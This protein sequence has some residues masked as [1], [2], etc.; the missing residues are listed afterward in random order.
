VDGLAHWS[1]TVQGAI[2]CIAN[3]AKAT[4]RIRGR[5]A[6]HSGRDGFLVRSASSQCEGRPAGRGEDGEK[7]SRGL[8]VPRRGGLLAPGCQVV[9][10][11][12][13]L[14]S[15]PASRLRA[16]PAARGII[17]SPGGYESFGMPMHTSSIRPAGLGCGRYSG[18]AVNYCQ[19]IIR[20][21]ELGWRLTKAVEGRRRRGSRASGATVASRLPVVCAGRDNARRDNGG[22]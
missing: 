6:Y 11:A 17:T 9:D 21:H 5:S 13:I 2:C 16:G 8:K 12:P 10:A 19:S 15:K 22:K 7:Q 20:Y 3:S 1:L 4:V 14:S 18:A